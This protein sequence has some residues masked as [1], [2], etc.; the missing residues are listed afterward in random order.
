MSK[1]ELNLPKVLEDRARGSKYGV[2]IE[3]GRVSKCQSSCV[4]FSILTYLNQLGL[5]RYM[6]WG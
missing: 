5:F 2:L 1:L 4:S 6:L 3:I